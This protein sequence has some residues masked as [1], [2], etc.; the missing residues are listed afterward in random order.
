PCNGTYG[1][2]QQ[3]GNPSPLYLH[4]RHIS[5]PGSP[6]HTSSLQPSLSHRGQLFTQ[7]RIDGGLSRN[8]PLD[9]FR[10]VPPDAPVSVVHRARDVG[11]QGHV[12][13]RPQRAVGR[14]RFRVGHVEASPETSFLELR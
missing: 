10:H 11:R 13:Q 1:E 5:F 9:L 14:G 4:P 6:P 2:N 7:N 12:G 3:Q 8:E